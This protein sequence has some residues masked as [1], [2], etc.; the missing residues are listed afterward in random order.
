MDFP[1][2]EVRPGDS[3]RC[4]GHHSD[5]ASDRYYAEDAFKT[6]VL[7]D[8]VWTIHEW[9]RADVYG[10]E[11]S[12]SDHQA[13]RAYVGDIA[14]HVR[15]REALGRI[16]TVHPISTPWGKSQ[17]ATVYA[18]GIVFHSTAGHGGFKLDRMR[19]KAMPEALR[20]AG[21]WYEEDGDWARVAAGYPDLFT[22]RE[23]A[24]ADRILRDWCPD[25]WEAIHGRALAPGESFSR[26]RDEFSRRHT[27]DWV[28]ISARTTASPPGYVEVIASLGGRRDASPK[29]AFLVPGEDYAHRGRHGFVID[30]D[31][32]GE[33]ELSPR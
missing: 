15:Q 22:Y 31:R 23:Q 33:I 11:C 17:T 20:I 13:F 18:P 28:V 24:S 9:N 30:P 1:E 12:V 19:N 4:F 5:E 26:E 8:D 32:H 16:E 3:L 2:I 7:G 6:G 14:L 29:R 21:G 27:Q 10:A 25:A